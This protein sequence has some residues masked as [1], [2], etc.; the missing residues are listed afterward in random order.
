VAL[1]EPP[2]C[3]AIPEG[4]DRGVKAD[5]VA[6]YVFGFLGRVPTVF[7]HAAEG[8]ERRLSR[9]HLSLPAATDPSKPG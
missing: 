4:D 8:S 3:E 7:D 2:D 6:P 1:V 9:D 5:A